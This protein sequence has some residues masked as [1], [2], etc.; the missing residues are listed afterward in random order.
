[1]PGLLADSH[2]RISEALVGL[3]RADPATPGCD[4]AVLEVVEALEAHSQVGDVTVH[5]LCSQGVS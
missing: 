4:V 1:M 3:S 5:G 2:T